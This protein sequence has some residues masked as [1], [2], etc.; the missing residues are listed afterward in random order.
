MITQC[1]HT[2]GGR[3]AGDFVGFLDGHR[4]AVQRA[5]VLAPAQRLVRL[6]GAFAGLLETTHHHRVQG[7]VEALDTVNEVLQGSLGGDL[8]IL[9]ASGQSRSAD[10]V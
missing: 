2:G 8:S 3:P 5:P 9:D 7:T 6:A 4:H 10:T 1:F